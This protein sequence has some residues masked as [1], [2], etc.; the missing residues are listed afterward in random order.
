[1]MLLVRISNGWHTEECDAV[2]VGLVNNGRH[3]V[4]VTAEGDF[5]VRDMDED[6]IKS[7]HITEA[8]DRES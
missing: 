3:L 2:S 5:V 1:M 8:P 4:I 6:E 7:V